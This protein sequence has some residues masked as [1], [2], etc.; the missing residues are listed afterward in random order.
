MENAMKHKN[1][2][3]LALA[4][5][6]AFSF[7]LSVSQTEIKTEKIKVPII[8]QS[9]KHDSKNSSLEDGNRHFVADKEAQKLRDELFNGQHPQTI[10]LACSDSRVV[11]EFIFDKTMGELF[12][13]RTA[14]NVVDSVALGSIE[15]A[16]EHLHSPNLLVLG[17][18]KCGAVTAACSGKTES[19]F[20]N[21]IITSIE[22][23]VEEAK[24][25]HKAGDELINE[26][27]RINVKNQIKSV[28][29]SKIIRELQEEGKLKI[30]GGIY[31]IK[32]GKVE[33]MKEEKSE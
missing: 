28:L 23:A 4:L 7:N 30:I 25:D 13:I 27:I 12:V 3:T 16:A 29:R 15:Y 10:V 9:T 32:N 31:D 33:L 24:H 22:P 21:T 1:I 5:A 14:G 19:P 2:F 17:H 11:P 26:A 8:K 6:L 18:T 20:L